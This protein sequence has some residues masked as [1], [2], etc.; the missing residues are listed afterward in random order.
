VVTFNEILAETNFCSSRF[1]VQPKSM[2][3]GSFTPKDR[4]ANRLVLEQ[5]VAE[6]EKNS[7]SVSEFHLTNVNVCNVVEGD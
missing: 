2:K 6:Q 5:H 3:K 1:I 7:S 4:E